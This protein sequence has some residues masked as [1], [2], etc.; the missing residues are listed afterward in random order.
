MKP[1]NGI[2]AC[3]HVANGHAAA[4]PISLKNS[5]RL[6]FR[7]TL[8][9]GMESAQPSTLEGSLRLSAKVAMGQFRHFERPL[10]MSAMPPIATETV[11]R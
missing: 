9:Q 8:G 5:R 4:P 10:E 7:P 11:R 3:A 2:A 6:I 1:I